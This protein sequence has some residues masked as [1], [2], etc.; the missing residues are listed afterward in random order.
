MIV[1]FLKS[2]KNFSY[3]SLFS[4]NQILF[5]KNIIVIAVIHKKFLENRK[6]NMKKKK[7]R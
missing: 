2:I 7:L 3:Q 1:I 4:L 6:K 5:I